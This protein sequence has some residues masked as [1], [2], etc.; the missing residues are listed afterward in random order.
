MNPSNYID[1]FR[2]KAVRHNAINHDQ[3]S[4]TGDSAHGGQRFARISAEDVITGLRSK[5]SFPALMVEMFE[6]RTKAQSI[7]DVKGEYVGAF[8]VYASASLS[9]VNEQESAF[10][11]AWEIINDIIREI[12]ADH[13]GRNK[14][15][16]QTPFQDVSFNM[17]ILPV[18][19]VFEKEFGWRCE[20]SFSPKISPS[21]ASA[22]ADGIFK[23][24]AQ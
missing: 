1:Y 6:V 20:F 7:Y 10:Q 18:G 5:I 24:Y 11:L 8:S 4:E 21:L 9:N 16:C 2:Q 3:G 15:R 22:P 17:E 23:P 19:P 14:D 13:Y 12:W